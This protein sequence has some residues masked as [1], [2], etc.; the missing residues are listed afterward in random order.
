MLKRNKLKTTCALVA[1]V[2]CML[3]VKLHYAYEEASPLLLQN[4]D[5]LSSGEIRGGYN[6]IMYD[7]KTREGEGRTCG[8]WSIDG[9]EPECA[10]IDC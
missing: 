9:K 6:P 1:L 3:S 5:A 10:D 4:I 8:K 7:C 2:A